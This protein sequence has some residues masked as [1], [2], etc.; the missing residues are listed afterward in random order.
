M[1]RKIFKKTMSFLSG[2]YRDKR[3][4]DDATLDSWYRMFGEFDAD[5]FDEV[6]RL[7]VEKEF[8]SPNVSDLIESC[9]FKQRAVVSDKPQKTQTSDEWYAAM[10]EKYGSE[11]V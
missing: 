8:K 6:C 4:M 7:W 10:V 2:A 9:R 1:D 3:Y 11:D 5:V